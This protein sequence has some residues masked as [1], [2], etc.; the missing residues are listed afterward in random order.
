MPTSILKA[1]ALSLAFTLPSVVAKADVGTQFLSAFVVAP[2]APFL[3]G[4]A[5][6][7]SADGSSSAAR[8]GDFGGVN[9]LTTFTVPARMNAGYGLSQFS[10]DN[11]SFVYTGVTGVPSLTFG[12]YTG[13]QPLGNGAAGYQNVLANTVSYGSF[14]TL[15]SFDPTRPSVAPPIQDASFLQAVNA[16]VRQ[17]GS[18]TFVVTSGTLGLGGPQGAGAPGPVAGAGLPFLLVA[19]AAWLARRRRSVR[20]A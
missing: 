12:L 2:N 11:V 18:A 4:S 9:S 7:L 10:A 19:G 14:N 17:T 5:L 20:S 13:S 1:L 8:S 3:S 6:G 15:P 16:M